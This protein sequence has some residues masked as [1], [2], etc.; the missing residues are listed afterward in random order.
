MTGDYVLLMLF[1]WFHFLA[2]ITWIGLLY[3]LN[4]INVRFS[5][6][7]DAAIR[8]QV[9]PQLLSR[10]LAWF[11]HSAWVTVVAGFV[12][13]YL[14]YWN[15]GDVVTTN[16]AKTILMGSILG[17]LMALNV[18]VFIWPNQKKIINAMRTGTAADPAWGRVALYVSRTNFTLSF[19][20][21][22]FMGGASHF[23][24]DWAGIVICGVLASV[25]GLL[26]WNTVQRWAPSKF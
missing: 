19:P 11:R 5:P 7:L 18:W 20:M 14:S 24:L 16:S 25:I 23:P 15:H 10:V 17:T 3:F 6:S 26:V 21:L 1:R 9:M 2:G 4:L 12:L 22:F 8:P 13:I